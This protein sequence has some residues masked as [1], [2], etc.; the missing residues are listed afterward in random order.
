[1]GDTKKFWQNGNS[2]LHTR[3]F[4]FLSPMSIKLSRNTKYTLTASKS[5]E[6]GVG[7]GLA[8]FK[9]GN[10]LKSKTYKLNSNCS[11]FQAELSA[12]HQALLVARED[13]LFPVSVISDS[14][15]SLQDMNNRSSKNRQVT[16]IKEIYGEMLELGLSVKL[17]LDKSSRG[18]IREWESGWTGQ[19]R[20]DQWQTL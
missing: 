16:E 4:E 12:I 11:V 5:D 2:L 13:N 9:N 20:L 1:M 6:H 14:F 8:V 17:L 15:S 3:G 18:T 10:E 7:S 19:T